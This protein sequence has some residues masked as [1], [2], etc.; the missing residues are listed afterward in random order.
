MTP[1]DKR[2]KIADMVLIKWHKKANQWC[3]SE[4]KNGA[5]KVS[6]HFSKEHVII[7]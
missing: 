5:Q 3:R 6:F 2:I 1:N 4:W 7:K